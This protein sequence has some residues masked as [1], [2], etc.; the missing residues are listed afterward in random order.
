MVPSAKPGAQGVAIAQGAQGG[1]NVALAVEAEHVVLG[2]MQVVGAD[3][4]GHRQSVGCARA[5]S[6]AAR[7]VG[8]AAENGCARRSRGPVRDRGRPRRSPPPPECPAGPAGSLPAPS[9]TAPLLAR[10]GSAGLMNT[11][12]SKV[13]AYS[14]ARRSTRVLAMGRP[15]SLTPTQPAS[16]SAAISASR[17]PRKRYVKAPSVNTRAWPAALAR[18]RIHSTTDG[19][20]M[21]G[22]VS[23]GQTRVVMPAAAAARVSL[24]MLALCSWPGSRSRA[25][26]SIRPGQT[27]RSRASMSRSTAKP[28][29]AR[30]IPAILAVRR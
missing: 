17:S 29:G 6:S 13:A 18:R 2:Q 22:S 24:A 7:G 12:R 30:P 10:W 19:S 26:R 8:Q 15:P 25:H 28:S 20:S 9:W 21:A 11:V 3:I 5:I 4:G 14:S 1:H 27:M 23:G 16:L